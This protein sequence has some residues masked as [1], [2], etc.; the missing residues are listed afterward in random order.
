MGRNAN[1]SSSRSAITRNGRFVAFVSFATNLAPAAANAPPIFV[2]DRLS[3]T[4][5]RIGSTAPFTVSYPDNLS[6]SD[7]GR[8]IV[9]E[10]NGPE[11]LPEINVFLYD[12]Q[13][14]K[15]ER[16]SI[17]ASGDPFEP[18]GASSSPSISPDGRYVGLRLGWQ[19][20]RPC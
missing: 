13:L 8:Y 7:D 17:A 12:R 4:T 18:T 16:I 3:D 2:R 1:D 10:A 14:R 6:I 19:Q 5:Q 15:T 20:P 9:F 11:P